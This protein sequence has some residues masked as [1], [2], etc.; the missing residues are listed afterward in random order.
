MITVTSV[1]SVICSVYFSDPTLSQLDERLVR[2]LAYQRLQQLGG[3]KVSLFS[4]FEQ[5][6]LIFCKLEIVYPLPYLHSLRT[7]KSC[8]GVSFTNSPNFFVCLVSHFECC[9]CKLT[10]SDLG[11]T[12]SRC[13]SCMSILSY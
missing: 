10:Q 3:K 7:V 12:L 4:L 1:Y 13:K 8:E 9:L 5:L 6:S 11:R 2:V